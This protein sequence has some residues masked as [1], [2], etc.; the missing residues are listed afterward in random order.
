MDKPS[1]LPD[2]V[3]DYG[4]AFWWEEMVYMSATGSVRGISVVNN[5]L[6]LSD[7]LGRHTVLSQN[8]KDV[9]DKWWYDIF[10]SKFL[11]NEHDE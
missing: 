8:I 3:T 6:E 5:R 9:Y 4:S 2:Y 7:N 10:E 11:G 1:R